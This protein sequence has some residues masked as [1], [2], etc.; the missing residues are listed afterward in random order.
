LSVRIV[1][2]TVAR[3]SS[4]V[5]AANPVIDLIMALKRHN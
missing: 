5:T 4:R 3:S 2:A 1:T